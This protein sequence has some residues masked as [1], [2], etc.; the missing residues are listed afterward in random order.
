MLTSNFIARFGMAITGIFFYYIFVYHI[1]KGEQL[2]GAALLAVFFNTINIATFIAMAPLAS[3]SARI[4]KK[5]TIILMLA[6][7]AVAYAS[8]MV[9]FTNTDDSFIRYSFA[10]GTGSWTIFVQWPSIITGVLIGV[11]TN[12]MPMITN[13]MIADVCDYDEL[14]CRKAARGILWRR[15][16]QHREDGVVGLLGVSGS[17]AG[18]V[19]FQCC[20]HPPGTRNHPVLVSCLSDHATGGIPGRHCDHPLLSAYPDPRRRD[21][22]EA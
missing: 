6:M 2:A 15:L 19:R 4:G 3:L 5:A 18:G 22:E 20:A 17:A 14:Q 16:H 13:S 11:F 12:T 8:L 1:G 7:S 9:T 21:P 10:F